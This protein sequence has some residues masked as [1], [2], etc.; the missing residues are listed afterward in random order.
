MWCH[1]SVIPYTSQITNNNL[2]NTF[3]WLKCREFIASYSALVNQ[4]VYSFTPFTSKPRN[5]PPSVLLHHYYKLH[6]EDGTPLK[7]LVIWHLHIIYSLLGPACWNILLF[8]LTLAC[9]LFTVNKINKN[10]VNTT[11]LQPPPKYCGPF[12]AAAVQTLKFLL[13]ATKQPLTQTA[14]SISAQSHSFSV[15]RVLFKKYHFFSLRN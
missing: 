5:Y 9:F 11:I 14:W 15:Y 10:A 6:S 1:C 8:V 7:P 12:Q 3:I 2:N 13:G 4:Y